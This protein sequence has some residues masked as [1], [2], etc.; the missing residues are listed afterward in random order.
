MKVGALYFFQIVHL[1]KI[2]LKTGKIFYNQLYKLGFK[3]GNLCTSTKLKHT[4]LKGQR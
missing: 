1:L 2:S 3:G 4:R